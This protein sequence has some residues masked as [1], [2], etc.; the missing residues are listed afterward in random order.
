[1]KKSICLILIILGFG[2]LT[3]TNHAQTTVF[4]ETLL[5]S[6]KPVGWDDFD[7]T[8]IST[9]ARL[10]TTDAFLATPSYDLSGW[11]NLVLTYEYGRYLVGGA[12]LVDVQISTDGVNWSAATITSS[13]PAA[14]SSST[15]T[16]VT[17]N[18]SSSFTPTT[19]TRIRW[20][21]VYGGIR[22]R[23]V[24]LQ[25]ISTDPTITVTP[26]MLSGFTYLQGNGPSSEQSFTV[27]GV[28]LTGN[29]VITPPI[30]Y[31][32]STTSGTNFVA[33]NPI[34][35]TQNSGVVIATQIFV[36][37]KD[38]LLQGTYNSELIT[39]SSLGALNKTVTC[40]GSVT[41]PTPVITM[42]PSTMTGFS[43]TE[44]SGPSPEQAF[45]VAGNN[46]TDV[47]T[48]TP[49]TFYE[50]STTSGTGFVASNPILLSHVSGSV[51]PTNVYVRLKAGLS[52]GNY[53]NEIIVASSPGAVNKNLTLSGNVLASNLPE[54]VNHVSNFMAIVQSNTSIKL[55]WADEPTASAY[56]IKMSSTSYAAI[57]APVDGTPVSNGNTAQNVTQGIESFTWTG[58]LPNTTYYFKIYPYTNSGSLINY[59][60][61]G[62]VPQT[63]ETTTTVS[64]ENREDNTWALIYPNPAKGF[65]HIQTDLNNPFTV[66]LLNILGNT[67]LEYNNTNNI[68][69]NTSGIESGLYFV[70]VIDNKGFF[71]TH[72]IIIE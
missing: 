1:M 41:V 5:T 36:R 37:L 16:S 28:N 20:A 51:N 7:V 38:A 27:S 10:T 63:F 35:L 40:N 70:K 14:A 2:L 26:N 64:F 49:P 8:Y 31:E 47:I 54:P 17:V 12:T 56:L 59:K 39:L 15:W 68:T 71:K 18:I 21:S 43:Y 44:G 33:Q 50:I 19:T 6:A 60:I 72:K 62:N 52:Y 53:N 4:Q 34:T 24:K 58:L 67:I 48:L 29:I 66:T 13:P 9:A 42:S 25:G 3:T 11:S 69:I 45:T 23:N 55:T 65:L 30:N 61:D 57:N 22:L 46:L 32:I